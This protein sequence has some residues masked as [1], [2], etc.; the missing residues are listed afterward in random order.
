MALT[1]SK[2]SLNAEKAGQWFD[3]LQ[4]LQITRRL[5]LMAMIAV[6]VAAG[7]SVFF[8]SQKPGMVPLY[9][10]LDQKATAEATD[11]L[12]AAQ[13]PFAL[14]G[15][16]DPD[17]TARF[18]AGQ[19]EQALLNL[20]RNAHESGVA[21]AQVTMALR[22]T[23]EGWRLDV[24]DRGAG[25]SDAVLANALLPFYST[26]RNGTGLGLALAREIAEAH[27]GRI[28][29]SNRID[30]GLCVSLVLPAD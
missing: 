13:I 3:R 5:G 11:L 19:V 2:D 15:T 22:R 16:L 10:G 14:E 6:A 27:G 29:L 17:A 21:E 20:L 1:L 24:L 7:L 28:A 18:D 8:W 23:S 25:M 9:T 4:S 26:K 12:R 30:G